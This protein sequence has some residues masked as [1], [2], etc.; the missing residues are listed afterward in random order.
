[1]RDVTVAQANTL[2]PLLQRQLQAA[3]HTCEVKAR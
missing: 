3:N 1:M 2:I